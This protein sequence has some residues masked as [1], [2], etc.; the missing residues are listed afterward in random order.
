MSGIHVLEPSRI[1]GRARDRCQRRTRSRRDEADV[2]GPTCVLRF[3]SPLRRRYV[4]GPAFGFLIGTRGCARERRTVS[5]AGQT[6]DR[7]AGARGARGLR[8]TFEEFGRRRYRF[9]ARALATTIQNSTHS[10]TRPIRAQFSPGRPSSTWTRSCLTAIG[11]ADTYTNARQHARTAATSS[12]TRRRRAPRRR[13][14][15]SRSKSTSTFPLSPIPLT[16]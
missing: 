11:T 13:R 3:P 1:L 6:S 12:S 9:S 16:S 2:A 5:P 14:L 15:R 8:R 4:A 7:R 10:P